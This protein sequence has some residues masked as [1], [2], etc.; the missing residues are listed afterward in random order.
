MYDLPDGLTP[1]PDA[2]WKPPGNLRS[3][4]MNFVYSKS[5]SVIP[6]CSLMN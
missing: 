6:E 5:M 3:G 1:F 2:N 4:I